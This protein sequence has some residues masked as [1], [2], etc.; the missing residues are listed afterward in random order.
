MAFKSNSDRYCI[1]ALLKW[2]F[3]IYE[4]YKFWPNG[5]LQIKQNSQSSRNQIAFLQSSLYCGFYNAIP[6]HTDSIV[7]IIFEDAPLQVKTF[8]WSLTVILSG[9]VWPQYCMSLRVDCLI[10]CFKL[11]IRS[12]MSIFYKGHEIMNSYL[13]R[14]RTWL[15]MSLFIF[16]FKLSSSGMILHPDKMQKLCKNAWLK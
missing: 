10:L 3:P 2:I 15:R 16:R 4:W 12:H 8:H 6:Y 1:S 7:D 14:S 13:M 9:T 5:C 11:S